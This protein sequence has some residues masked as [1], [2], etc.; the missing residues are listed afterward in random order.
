MTLSSV[1]M[2]PGGTDPASS[3][4]SPCR[5]VTRCRG[6]VRVRG[7]GRLRAILSEDCDA[8]HVALPRR[9]LHYDRLNQHYK[10]AHELAWLVL[11]GTR[12][13]DDLY[14]TGDVR[15]FAFL[16]DMNRLFEVF[17]ER[18]LAVALKPLNVQ[19]AFQRPTASVVRRA[20]TGGQYL[21][22]IPDTVATFGDGSVRLPIDAKYKRYSGKSLEPADVAQGFIYA[23]GLGPGPG[24]GLPQGLIV[25]P[26]ESGSVEQTPLQVRHHE[27]APRAGLLALGVPVAKILDEVE[28]PAAE[29]PT[30][31]TVAE[32]VTAT[33]NAAG[34][35]SQ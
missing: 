31:G 30:L 29:Q 10:Q 21:R 5:Y 25:Y 34:A 27:G 12:G 4:K 22:L 7:L 1:T 26:S 24:A 15:S 16:L 13:L 8:S 14:A 17:V 19:L 9:D 3:T 33:A 23:A 2:S 32:A 35:I 11:E 20:D 18:L 28:R 6:R